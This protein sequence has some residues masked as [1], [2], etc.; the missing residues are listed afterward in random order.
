MVAQALIGWLLRAPRVGGVHFGDLR[1][2]APAGVL[3]TV[4]RQRV[5]SW[6]LARFLGA[7]REDIKGRILR[8]GGVWA[9]EDQEF[10]GAPGT[11]QVGRIGEHG[12]IEC[13]AEG[14]PMHENGFDCVL[15]AD[16]LFETRDLRRVIRELHLVLTPGGVLLTMFPGTVRLWTIS[17]GR[18]GYR[19]ISVKAA[20][21]LFAEVFPVEDLEVRGYGN[22]LTAVAALH[23]IRSDS[24]SEAELAHRDEAYAVSV[25]VSAR[26]P[27]AGERA[28][29]R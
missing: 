24:L 15:A 29:A 14:A 21:E 10:G 26:K 28:A 2:L 1:T 20:R 22:V 17:G 23:G 4:G 7:Y 9:D 12:H 16:V 25:G 27:A 6:Y 13:A 3:P 11:V 18:G 5:E 8:L 19:G